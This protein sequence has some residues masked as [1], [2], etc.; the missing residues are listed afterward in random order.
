MTRATTVRPW[1]TL[2]Q[3]IGPLVQPYAPQFVEE[4]HEA[5]EREIPVFLSVARTDPN[6][7]SDVE[8]AVNLAATSFLSLIGHDEPALSPESRDVFTRLGADEAREGRGVE[9]LLAA[10]RVGARLALRI[11]V[12]ALEDAGRLDADILGTLSDAIFGYVDDVSD[13]SAKGYTE[14]LLASSGVRVQQRRDLIQRMLTG[15]GGPEIERL[16]DEVHWP[17]RSLVYTLATDRNAA[18][19]VA[20]RLGESAL[21][22]EDDEVATFIVSSA[23]F[24]LLSLARAL[25][26]IDVGVGPLTP[27]EASSQSA[28]LARRV[29]S[30]GGCLR[31]ATDRLASLAVNGDPVALEALSQRVLAP[32]DH[33]REGS[34][35]RLLDTLALW[36]RHWGQRG[37]VA[38]ALA[39][40]PQTIGYR[41]G[42]LR[43]V[44][45]EQLDDPQSRF[46]L[47]VALYDR[48][49]TQAIRATDES[50][51]HAADGAP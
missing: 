12:L 22:V 24:N 40:H 48:P 37:P 26:G 23:S 30:R 51:R 45:G 4:L 38:E 10:Y 16:A 21:A 42:Q 33:I 36:L 31:F 29:W 6:F 17:L 3:D 19:E 15:S 41:L 7:S 27:W 47:A 5:L 20:R 11:I 44:L 49:V 14:E 8:M 34:R 39:V 46:E 43:D 50:P 32:F 2:P 28:H 35:E 25:E 9:T 1:R 18:S 13:A